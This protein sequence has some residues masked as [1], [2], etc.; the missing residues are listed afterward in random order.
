MSSL[1]ESSRTSVGIRPPSCTPFEAHRRTDR[2]CGGCRR[3][4]CAISSRTGAMCGEPLET[5]IIPTWNFSHL[6]KPWPAK[7]KSSCCTDRARTD[8]KAHVTTADRVIATCRRQADHSR[9]PSTAGFPI[10][11]APVARATARG[12][13]PLPPEREAASGSCGCCDAH[14]GHCSTV[15]RA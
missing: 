14:C 11:R 8:R 2:S 6:R 4:V 12:K 15:G 9:P 10:G 3:K 5:A 7:S 13:A 1:T